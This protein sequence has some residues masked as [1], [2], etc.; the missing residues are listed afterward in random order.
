MKNL[1][2]TPA[3][4][5]A[6]TPEEKPRKK[7]LAPAVERAIR[8]LTLLESAPQH[9]FGVSEIARTL[10]VPK[11]TV[12]NIC[13]ALV[14]GQLVRRTEDGYQLGRRLV[15]LG[16]A[17]V[18]S[19][20]L[21]REFYDVCRMASPDIESMIQL[22]VLS[23]GL[24]VIYLARQDYNSGLQLGLRAEIGRRTP[25]NCTGIGKALLAALPIHELETRL[26]GV[27]TLPTL[28]EKSIATPGELRERLDAIRKT[29]YSLDD[30]EVL[31][32]VS[33]IARCASTLHR[34]DGLVAVSITS[35]KETCTPEADEKRKKT[36]FQIVQALEER[37]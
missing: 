4:N 15:Q 5:A 37:L 34:E 28:T 6:S 23:D 10:D 31:P 33:C 7:T 1:A 25:A 22:A 3:G 36:L 27:R 29:G 35:R 32:G 14:D 24:D 20:H 26:A 13:D 17:Y 11:S 19:V 2:S 16:S 9:R 30:E 21:V 8:I 12:L 18:S